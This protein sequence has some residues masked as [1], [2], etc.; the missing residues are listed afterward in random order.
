MAQKSGSG[1]APWMRGGTGQ[2][3]PDG[4]EERARGTSLRAP[5]LTVFSNSD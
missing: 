2:K 3:Q 5:H 1:L 4:A